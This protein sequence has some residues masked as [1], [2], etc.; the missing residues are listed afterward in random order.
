MFG[1]MAIHLIP[2]A[3]T[4][5]W[6]LSTAQ[7]EADL[8]RELIPSVAAMRQALSNSK[9]LASEVKTWNSENLS[10]PICLARALDIMKNLDGYL[11]SREKPLGERLNKELRFAHIWIPPEKRKQYHED[12]KPHVSINTAAIKHILL[13]VALKNPAAFAE[14]ED[15]E[16]MLELMILVFNTLGDPTQFSSPHALLKDAKIPHVSV[17]SS[18]AENKMALALGIK[19]QCRFL[20]SG[21]MTKVSQIYATFSSPILTSEANRCPST[22]Y[23]Y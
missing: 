23:L 7:L 3:N 12:E 4:D 14:K 18:Q 21:A 16:L 13:A 6:K 15:K 20:V 11:E 5:I 10:P 2:D 8:L 9:V 17:L 22:L 19:E 1:D